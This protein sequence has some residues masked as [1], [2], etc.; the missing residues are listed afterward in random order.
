M[1]P[2]AEASG[3]GPVR[4][5]GTSEREDAGAMV[6]CMRVLRMTVKYVVVKDE[7]GLFPNGAAKLPRELGLVRRDDGNIDL[8]EVQARVDE[9]QA[10]Y[11]VLRSQ[12]DASVEG[13]ADGL[14]KV[15]EYDPPTRDLL[16]LAMHANRCKPLRQALNIFKDVDEDDAAHFFGEVL[17]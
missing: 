14:S 13:I 6:A 12:S 11:S 8:K 1:N 10:R 15:F 9:M 3:I 7:S 17:G 4:T 5:L 16:E 2:L